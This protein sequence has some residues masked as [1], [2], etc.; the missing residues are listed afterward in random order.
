[1]AALWG[2]TPNHFDR[3]YRVHI[4]TALTRTKPGSRLKQFESAA[5]RAIHDALLAQEQERLRLN[6]DE[7]LLL[8]GGGNDPAMHR[9]RLAKAQLAEL[10]LQQRRNQ[11]I[12]I[13]V[14]ERLVGIVGSKIRTAG[15][16]LTRKYG[17]DAGAIIDQALTEAEEDIETTLGSSD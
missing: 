16:L 11:V 2:V 17:N 13:D 14:A 4:P 15:E 9:L 5:V 12:E 10:D 6:D 8:E 7:A 3:Q 1:M